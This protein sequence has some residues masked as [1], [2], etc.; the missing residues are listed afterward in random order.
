MP[1]RTL[2]PDQTLTCIS[3]STAWERKWGCYKPAELG[4][5]VWAASVPR[6]KVSGSTSLAPGLSLPRK[7]S[8]ERR[9]GGLV[10]VASFSLGSGRRLLFPGA[11]RQGA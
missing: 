4:G 1:R 5:L 9:G 11:A 3:A 7:M 8:S 2:R 10:W 6:A